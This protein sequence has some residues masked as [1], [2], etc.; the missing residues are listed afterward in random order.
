MILLA[1]PGSQPSG[2]ELTVAGRTLDMTGEAFRGHGLWAAR[3]LAELGSAL[4]LTQQVLCEAGYL[5]YLWTQEH[6]ASSDQTAA[7]MIHLRLNLPVYIHR[8]AAALDNVSSSE[9][10]IRLLWMTHPFCHRKYTDWNTV[11]KRSVT[12]LILGTVTGVKSLWSRNVI[13][14]LTFSIGF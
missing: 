1:F 4:T 14:L 7:Q 3:T 2:T 11:R 10:P 5:H 12:T 6:R 13:L 8:S 9:D